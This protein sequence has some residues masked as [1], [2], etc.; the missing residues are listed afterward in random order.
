MSYIFYFCL[1]NPPTILNLLLG[2]GRYT[3]LC[4]SW[5]GSRL[6]SSVWSVSHYVVRCPLV[7]TVS[8]SN[9][10]YTVDLRER[11]RRG[12]EEEDGDV[13][14]EVRLGESEGD[15]Q[16]GNIGGGSDGGSCEKENGE[17]CKDIKGDAAVDLFLGKIVEGYNHRDL[18]NHQNN[19]SCLN[20]EIVLR[21]KLETELSDTQKEL[22]E[23]QRWEVE[24]RS[25]LDRLPKHLGDV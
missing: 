7:S 18:E 5:P 2:Y 20:E 13:G 14:E 4:Y 3:L 6:V 23:A 22:T 24:T 15:R 12:D 9:V 1:N 17:E 10:Y 25:F 21:L 8:L 19:I 16:T 11:R